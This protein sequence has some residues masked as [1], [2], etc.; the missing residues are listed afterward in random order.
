AQWDAF[1]QDASAQDL[2]D[3][4]DGDGDGRADDFVGHGT[5]T[6]G[7][8]LACAPDASIVAIRVL[9]DEGR[10]NEAALARGID[11]ARE[12]GADVI[13]LSLVAPTAGPA[14]RDALDA[15]VD[16]GIVL[17][18][19]AGDD[20]IGPFNSTFLCEHAIVVGAIDDTMTVPSFSPNSSMVDV[21]A[22][23]VD[24]VGPL[25][26]S[27]ANSYAGWTGTSFSAPFVSAA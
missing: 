18:V 12:L 1:D 26:G 8:V 7:L 11:K 15:A 5:F 3:A 16:A 20:P 2:G 13:N 27:I 6:S 4:L 23:G 19:S 21:F 22:P 9:D 14:L 17:V 10:G 25:G 24:I